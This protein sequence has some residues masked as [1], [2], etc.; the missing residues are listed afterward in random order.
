[1]DFTESHYQ[2]LAREIRY[3]YSSSSISYLMGWTH[4]ETLI[5]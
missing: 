2:H 1:M 5:L 4:W 3:I